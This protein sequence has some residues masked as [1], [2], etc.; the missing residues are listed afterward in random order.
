M[1]VNKKLHETKYIDKEKDIV[2]FGTGIVIGD[3][4]FDDYT[5]SSFYDDLI[6]D[7]EYMSKHYN[8]KGDVVMM[9][10]NE[11][12][13]E[14]AEK[15]FNTS[16]SSLRKQREID[17]FTLQEIEDLIVKYKRQVFLPYINYAEK[18]QEGLHRMY[19]AGELFG[20]NH[21]FPVLA[22]NWV[23]EEKHKKAEHDRYI[24][25]V[26]NKVESAFN[27]C[28]RYE[29]YSSYDDFEDCLQYALDSEFE[30]SDDIKT[31]VDFDFD[32]DGDNAIITIDDIETVLDSHLIKIVESD[33]EDE[34]DDYQDL[35]DISDDVLLDDDSFNALIDSILK[36]N[37]KR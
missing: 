9:T 27:K 6:K 8:L 4:I 7:P 32:I 34:E 30:F 29:E 18:S 17:E 16:V 3:D 35:N 28:T 13:K 37:I 11:Y 36:K 12:F 21:K 15:V 5:H 2:D 10:P 25:R 31:P 26:Q 19:V 33:E 23:D 14:C 20:W 22:I 24:N 1:R